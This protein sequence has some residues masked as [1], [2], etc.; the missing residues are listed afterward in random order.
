MD[1]LKEDDAKVNVKNPVSKFHDERLSGMSARSKDKGKRLKPLQSTSSGCLSVKSEQSIEPPL[2]FNHKQLKPLQS[3][4]SGCLSVKSEQSIEPPLVFNHKQLERP[5]CDY[6]VYETDL[7]STDNSPHSDNQI[8]SS[9]GVPKHWGRNRIWDQPRL[10][11]Q[12]PPSAVY[13]VLSSDHRVPVDLMQ[14]R[15]KLK[16]TDTPSASKDALDK[17]A[18]VTGP[19]SS[20]ESQRTIQGMDLRPRPNVSRYYPE[21]TES[22][23]SSDPSDNSSTMTSG[24]RDSQYDEQTVLCDDIDEEVI[25]DICRQRVAVKTCLTCNTSYCEYHARHHYTVD[26]LQRHTLKD[27]CAEVEGKRCLHY[28]KSLD[29]FC[30]TD[31]MQICSICTKRN[32]RGHD[33]ISQ[34]AQRAASQML[35]GEDCQEPDQPVK[36]VPPPGKIEFQ[37][38]KPNSLI[39]S[40]GCPEGLDGPKSFQV[41][42]SSLMKVEGC[43]PIKDSLKIE[44]NNLQLG[45]KYFFSVATEDEDGNFS[46]C[47]T[48]SVF[49]AVP[50]PRHLTKGHSEATAL[51]LKWT[52]ADNMEG[53]PHQF[54]ITVTSPG[55]ESSVIHTE[56]CYKMFSDLEPDTK[57]S[58]S[59]S[60]VLN[61]QSSQPAS[62]TIHT[63]P[64]LREVLSKMGL[65]DQYDNKLTLSTVL[66]ISQNDTSEN[67]LETA[68]S[69][70]GAF[71]RRLMMLNAN[72]RC[73][74]C[75]SC[76]VDTDKSN[77]I[78]PLDLITALLLCSDSFLQQ[79]IV[80]KMALCQ[81]A[82]PLLLPNSE[83]REITMMLWSMREIV[84]TFR[85]SMQ[86]FRKLNCEERIVHSDI[87]LVSFVRLG[88]TSLS[89]S[90]IL[91]KLLS[92]TT[93][94]HNSTFYNRDM[95]CGEVPRRISGGL[96]EIS[97]YLPCGN[98]SV[99]KFIEPLAVANLRGDIRAFDEQ[100]SFLCETSA[101]V[102]I[103]CDESE[104]DYF[105][106]LEGKDVKANVF[107]ISSVL[108]KSFTLKRMI[109]E[110]RLKIT[111]VSQKKKTDM[112]LIKALQESISK[113]LENYQNIVSVANQADRA[114]WCGILVDED[115]DECQSAWK[116]V[117]KITKCITD[118]SEFKDKQLPL[119]GHIWK[120]LSWLETE[121]WR[122]RKAGNQNTDVYRKSLQAKEK[123]LK[124]KQQRFE[125]T[126]AMLNFLH[127][128]VTSE[129]QRY[130]FLKWMEMELDDLSRQQVSSLQDRYKELLQ[131]S[132]HDAEKIAEIDKQISVCSLRLEH[133]FGECGRLYECTS[134]MPEYSRQ[135]KTRE[136]L[137]SLF[138]Q[139]LLDGFPLELVDG[140]AANI[141]MKWI[142]DVLTELHY[143]MQSNSKLKV[144]TIIGAEN[145]GKSTL[146]NTMFGVRFAVSKGTC[147]R[148]AFIQ[149]IN[150][151]KDMRKE[152]G[153]DCIM[154][155]DTEGLKPDQMVQDDHSHERDKEVASLCVALSDV[156]IVTVSRDNSREKDILELVLHAFT[157]LKDASKKP[158]CHFVHANMSDMPVVERKRRDKELMEQL[159][160]LIRKDAGM[161]KADITKV[162]DVMEFDPDTCS[163]YIPPLWHGTPPMAHFSVDYSETAHAL[164]KRLIGDLAKCKERGD[165]THFV[166]RVEN[167]WKAV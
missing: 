80:L 81:F 117:D 136:Q 123:E 56:D 140:D 114:R 64:C 71:L 10:T 37:S 4:S 28:E 135:R 157:R 19:R 84:R 45:Q 1:S 154:V 88:R 78:N 57:Y 164:K 9:W 165:L 105:K 62:I 104:M 74:K 30:R 125:I 31:Q 85:P 67:K 113:M 41:R 153:C 95:V 163:W 68:K 12:C 24:S 116:D 63:E 167:F 6:T 161:K 75:V 32:H 108:G 25:C 139:L 130:Y 91:N 97:W 18:K 38:V 40:W 96:V 133:F 155:I 55:K 143:S 152:M 7:S 69:L 36:V 20:L 166:R 54:L 51:S 112:E 72:A 26:T 148:G 147:T 87:P 121:C 34:R 35:G 14:S 77:A 158:L 21:T 13:P 43:L 122:L 16:A 22:T 3:T 39:L 89:K 98:R 17:Q 15:M 115:S 137:P 150:V 76:D 110:P 5:N 124:K 101:A 11:P 92:N 141:Q 58:I 2:V 149:L 138:A 29:F 111:N 48:A 126:T 144:V 107:L 59:V 61:G 66:E 118:T 49:T 90:L 99:D 160:E 128:V 47:I 52:K 46:E 44:I 162:S 83:T 109:K 146:L 50:P 53:I 102:Y 100:F 42:W 129:V 134:Y 120:A 156:T 60:T 142:T 127:G 82:V 33:I 94:Y 65:E 79:D 73:V 151:N 132:P 70:P 23:F 27:V 106:R 159:S 86:A 93:Q 119:R 131:K 145:S 103:F 8:R